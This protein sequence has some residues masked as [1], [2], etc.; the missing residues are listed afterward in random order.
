MAVHRQMQRICWNG[1]KCTEE[2][3]YERAW[4]DLVHCRVLEEALGGQ[5]A[6][7]FH[8]ITLCR[9]I[10]AFN[11]NDSA[12]RENKVDYGTFLQPTRGRS[13]QAAVA[14]VTLP[15]T[16]HART[17]ALI[18]SPSQLTQGPSSLIRL[19]QAG[20]A[21]SWPDHGG[22]HQALIDV[23]QVCAM[24]RSLTQPRTGGERRAAAA[25]AISV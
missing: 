4:N 15:A 20:W 12:L 17:L 13:P 24:R 6:T 7:D 5:D 25:A 21:P 22:R 2:I 23:P 9:T 10:K 1:L 8:N 16:V 14:F 11:D 18:Q 19:F 3:G